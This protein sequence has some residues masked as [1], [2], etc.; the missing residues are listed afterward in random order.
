MVRKRKAQGILEY[1][2]LLGAIIAVIVAVLMGNTG[3]AHQM[4]DTY[5]RVGDAAAGTTH[6]QFGIFANTGEGVGEGVGE[7][8]AG[9]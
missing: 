2:L 8:V 4:H 1:T 9:E 3:I 5:K 7:R 6:S